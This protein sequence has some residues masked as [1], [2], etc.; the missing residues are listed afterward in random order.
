MLAQIDEHTQT[1][2]RVFAAALRLLL[3]RLKT[4]EERTGT[5]LLSC[6][7]WTR[8]HSTTHHIPGLW[9]SPDEFIT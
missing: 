9:A 6:L 2:A 4:V 3:G 8:L 1:D 5:A 7:N